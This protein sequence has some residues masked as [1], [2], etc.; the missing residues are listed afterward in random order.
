MASGNPLLTG[1][2]P[3]EDRLGFLTSAS[4]PSNSRDPLDPRQFGCPGRQGSVPV[5]L[6]R[7]VNDWRLTRDNKDDLL[8]DTR[9]CRASTWV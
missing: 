7:A 5:M 2:T 6:V 3:P 8:T 9:Y 4:D 1:R